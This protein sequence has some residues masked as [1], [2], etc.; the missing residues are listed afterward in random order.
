[1]GRVARGVIGIRLADDQQVVSMLVLSEGDILTVTANGFG[2]HTAVDGH[3]MQGRGGQ[4][5]IGIQTSERN[6]ELISAIQALDED[7]VMLI[8]N[9][10]TLVRTSVHEISTLGRNTQGVTL[11]RLRNEEQLVGIARIEE[12]AEEEVEEAVEAD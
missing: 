12:D 11:I 9:G 8:S 6:G 4:G 5:V 2:K 3:P 7:D 1:M 10:G